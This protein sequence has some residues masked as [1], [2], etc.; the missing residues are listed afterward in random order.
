MEEWI[1]AEATTRKL[2]FGF[3]FEGI[4]SHRFFF[5]ELRFGGVLSAN[6]SE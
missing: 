5:F 4:F 2:F 3:A 1:I 6:R